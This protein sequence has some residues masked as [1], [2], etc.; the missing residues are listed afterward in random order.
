MSYLDQL[1]LQVLCV[2]E[3][4]SPLMSTLP[5]DQP[6][7][8]DGFVG[9]HGR[10]RVF[11]FHPSTVASLFPGTPDS[12]FLRCVGRTLAAS[13]HRVSQLHSSTP[14]LLAVDSDIWFLPAQS[15]STG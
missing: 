9:T 4:Q 12:Q 15:L 10:E 2:Q 3:N 8:Y 7:R 5:V 6:F 11:L 1:G 13:V 14:L